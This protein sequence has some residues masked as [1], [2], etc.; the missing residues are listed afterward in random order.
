[1]R[2]LLIAGNWKMNTLRQ[3]ATALAGALAAA[4]PQEPASVEILVCPPFPYLLPVRDAVDGS[5]VQLGAQ[6]AY[7]EDPGAYTGEVALE[8]LLDVGCRWVIVGHSER[9]HVLGES[10]ELLNKKVK[11]A[12]A[13]G[14]K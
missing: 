7:P 12:L 11:A 10:D 4:Y 2:R 5:A 3:T 1:M 8:M 14:L 9:R 13:K 6:N